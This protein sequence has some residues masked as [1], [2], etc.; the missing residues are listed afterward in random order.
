M[1]IVNYHYTLLYKDA[2]DKQQ[3]ERGR[4]T[5]ILM[6]EDGKWLLIADHGGPNPASRK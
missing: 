3:M 1:A 2:E 6:K 5:D 4:F